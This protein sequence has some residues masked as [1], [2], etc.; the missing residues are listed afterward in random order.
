MHK[1]I[2]ANFPSNSVCQTPT[3]SLNS[4]CKKKKEHAC[5]PTQQEKLPGWQAN[6]QRA[7]LHTQR[8]LSDLAIIDH[9][10]SPQSLPLSL[11]LPHLLI[12][13]WEKQDKNPSIWLFTEKKLQ[14]YSVPSALWVMNNVGWWGN[15][16]DNRAGWY[17]VGF[18]CILGLDWNMFSNEEIFCRI[19]PNL[20]LVY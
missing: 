10:T 14:M 2:N 18:T 8:F 4:V 3:L 13:D 5:F 19:S 12:A 17:R 6:I 20:N 16:I 7:L 9:P 15:C 1:A 11:S